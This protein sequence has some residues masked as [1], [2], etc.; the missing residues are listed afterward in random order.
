MH[1]RNRQ[2]RRTSRRRSIFPDVPPTV[3][4]N[5]FEPSPS[6]THHY[7]RGV[8]RRSPTNYPGPPLIPERRLRYATL[9]DSGRMLTPPPSYSGTPPPSYTKK[10]W[11]TR[12]QQKWRKFKNTRKMPRARSPSPPVYASRSRGGSATRKKRN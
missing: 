10:N 12:L 5:P 4:V 8:Q 7:R 6:P 11:L 3:S 9:T 1:P 2:H